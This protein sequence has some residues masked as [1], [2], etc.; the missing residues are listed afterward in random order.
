MKKIEAIIRPG[1]VREVRE[2]LK[3]LGISGI[4]VTEIQGHGQQA[5][6]QQSWRGD[7]Y[8]IDLLPKMKI[9][10]V[11]LDNDVQ[12]ITST[13]ID[14]ARTGEVGDGKIFV[15]A[16]EAAIRIRTGESGEEVI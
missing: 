2:A 13:I 8:T 12:P 5:G 14:A 4:M 6:I 9:E 7:E 10:V 1:K 16:V 11:C 15:T 3:R